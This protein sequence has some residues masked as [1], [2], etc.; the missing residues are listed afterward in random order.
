MQKGNGPQIFFPQDIKCILGITIAISK[1]FIMQN[2]C[3]KWPYYFDHESSKF[4]NITM[5]CKHLAICQ[6]NNIIDR[7]Q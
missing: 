2:K 5:N 6:D 4:I 7:F 1:L 3:K